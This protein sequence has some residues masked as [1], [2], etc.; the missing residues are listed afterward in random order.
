MEKH[1]ISQFFG[2]S[3]DVDTDFFDANLV[4]DSRVF[5]DPFL[6]KNSE[7][8]EERALFDRFGD[9]FRYAYDLSTQIDSTRD[10]LRKLE[11]YLTIHEPKVINMGYT[12]ESND[13]HGP[14]LVSKL[15][16]FFV[17]TTARR[18][19]RETD[20]FPENRYNPVS[21]QAWTTG[22]GFDGIS[23]ITANLL[24]DY[25]IRYTQEQA[26]QYE[27]PLHRM[28][29]DTAG[30]DFEDMEWKSGGYFQ[31]PKNPV[32]PEQPLIFVP[33]R[34]LRGL[35]EVYDNT[36]TKVLSILRAD[37]ELS[38][39]F[40][41]LLEREAAKVTIEDIR[42]VFAEDSSIHKRYLEVIERE[43]DTPYDFKLDPLNILADKHYGELFKDFDLPAVDNCEKMN[44]LVE[45]LISVFQKDFEVADGWKDA[46]RKSGNSM[47]PL[48]EP[49]IG[50]KFRG[51]GLGI[52]SQYPEVAF[53]AEQGTNNG[54]IDFSIIY[55]DCRIMVELK[56]LKNNTKKGESET[57]AYLHGVQYQLPNYVENTNAK[58]AHYITGQHYDGE[59]GSEINH[60]PRNLEIDAIV[61]SVETNLKT[62]VT[63]FV[64]L[65]H[66]N[67]SMVPHGTASDL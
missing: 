2:I 60:T 30:F 54:F 19:V 50:R 12:A 29:L 51:M 24:M 8:E 67:V 55:K 41:S 7:I 47:I 64:K 10:N 6:I 40:A 20:A 63:S 33:H 11:R 44:E 18:F 48:S 3:E 58:Y 66:T 14:S 35:D 16:G 49:T 57:P 28:A 27:I 36:K 59:H 22:I 17:D 61:P 34:W 45:T 5:I 25:L 21:L 37:A 15:L 26:R 31:L 62:K 39:R 38:S 42:S 1:H 52:F 4:Y 53:I 43:R 56:L 23:D 65:K 46:W 9:F 32:H 13:G